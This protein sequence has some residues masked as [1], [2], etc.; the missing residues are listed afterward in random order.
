MAAG[1]SLSLPPPRA[2]AVRPPPLLSLRNV[3]TRI[4]CEISMNLLAVSASSA[5]VRASA[6]RTSSSGSCAHRETAGST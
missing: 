3:T 1:A 5:I 6:Q 4:H 2:L